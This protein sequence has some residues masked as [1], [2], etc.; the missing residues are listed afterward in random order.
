[1]CP[2]W[3][4]VCW[5]WRMDHFTERQSPRPLVALAYR[6]HASSFWHPC[7]LPLWTVCE[8]PQKASTR[9]ITTALAS[10]FSKNHPPLKYFKS[11]W[12]WG[13]YVTCLS[14]KHGGLCLISQNLDIYHKEVYNACLVIQNIWTFGLKLVDAEAGVPVRS[15]ILGAHSPNLS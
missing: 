12:L 2:R 5:G 10:S 6:P 7:A 3:E 13:N 9:L 1:M 4:T 15:L 11:M 14:S 8:H